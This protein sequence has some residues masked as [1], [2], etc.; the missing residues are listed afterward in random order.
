MKK[1]IIN[2]DMSADSVNEGGWYYN[3]PGVENYSLDEMRWS[4]GEGS[5]QVRRNST[6]GIPGFPNMMEIACTVAAPAPSPLSN[7]HVEIVVEDMDEYMWG[8]THGIPMTVQI[9]GLLHPGQYSLAIMPLNN[10]CAVVAPFTVSNDYDWTVTHRVTFPPATVG[11]DWSA[12]AKILFDLGSGSARQAAVPGQWQTS[13]AWCLAGN[14]QTNGSVNTI[15]IGGIQADPDPSNG[16]I[17]IPFR[18]LSKAEKYSAISRQF[19]KSMPT[20]MVCADGVNP[21]C[22]GS[23]SYVSQGGPQGVWVQF[24]QELRGAPSYAPPI[25][26][27]GAMNPLRGGA[28][29][30]RWVTLNDRQDSGLAQIFCLSTKGCYVHNPAAVPA[31]VFVVVDLFVNA[32]IFGS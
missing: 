16:A 22:L 4:V 19:Y 10:S 26:N 32:R 21:N 27:Y 13:A 20:V 9:F 25:V 18:H 23:L 24:A 3:A 28:S 2:G 5:V 12:G 8:S 11:T 14:N 17:P 30:G 31:G 7:A 29:A 15:M 6:A 1:L